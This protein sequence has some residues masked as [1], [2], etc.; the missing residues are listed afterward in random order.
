MKKQNLFWMGIFLIFISG[1]F[2]ASMVAVGLVEF[3]GARLH[4][5]IVNSE[6]I[7]DVPKPPELFYSNAIIKS[8]YGLIFLIPGIVII[9]KYRK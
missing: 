9:R 6:S 1:M 7:I 8:I 3:V 4:T 5:D 2:F